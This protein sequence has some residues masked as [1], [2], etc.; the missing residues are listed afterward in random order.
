LT[1]A[2]DS[3]AHEETRLSQA[4]KPRRSLRRAMPW[5]GRLATGS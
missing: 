4:R 5:G 2:L 1:G 3:N